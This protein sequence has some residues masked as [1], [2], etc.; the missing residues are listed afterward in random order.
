M[1]TDEHFK[2][3]LYSARIFYAVTVAESRA[4]LSARNSLL[5]S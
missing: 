1:T 5:L 3:A 4:V 2:E